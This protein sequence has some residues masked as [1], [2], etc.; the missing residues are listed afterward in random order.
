MQIDIKNVVFWGGFFQTHYNKFLNR[1]KYY[2][3]NFHWRSLQNHNDNHY[4]LFFICK[5][6]TNGLYYIVCM[7]WVPHLATGRTLAPQWD[8]HWAAGRILDC[9]PHFGMYAT[10]FGRWPHIGPKANIVTQ[11]NKLLYNNAKTLFGKTSITFIFISL[12]LIV[13]AP[14]IRAALTQL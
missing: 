13:A 14:E 4:F 12:N 11:N 1:Q 5:A 7:L 3:A 9:R 2:F 6:C 8:S 10:H